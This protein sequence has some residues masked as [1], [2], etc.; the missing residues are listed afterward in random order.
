MRRM[1]YYGGPSGFQMLLDV[2]GFTAFI[3]LVGRLG[4]TEA[5]ATSMTFSVSTLAF[6]PIYRL[7]LGR[8]RARRRAAGRKSR[9]PCRAS[10]RIP[11]SR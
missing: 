1:L 10:P 3:L 6:M 2:T 8:E 9:R 7:A 5:E 11:R 4:G